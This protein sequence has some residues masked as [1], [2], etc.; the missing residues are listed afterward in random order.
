MA[1]EHALKLEKE[2]NTSLLSIGAVAE[3]E[4]DQHLADHIQSSFLPEQVDSIKKLADMLTNLERVG[5]EGLGLFLFDRELLGDDEKV[6][7]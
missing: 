4:G 1:L 3:A 6:F 5:S 7:Q 2:V